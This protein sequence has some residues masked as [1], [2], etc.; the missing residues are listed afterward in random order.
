MT[1]LASDTPVRQT[2]PRLEQDAWGVVFCGG[3]SRRMGRDKAV[4]LLGGAS[5]IDRAVRALAPVTSRVILASGGTPRYPELGL[6]CVLDAEPGAG[7]L[8]GLA[9]ALSRLERAGATHA[10]VL[11]CDMPRVDARTFA[12]LLARAREE[13]ADVCLVQTEGGV[14]PLF[15]VYHVRVRRAVAAALARGERRMIAFH[16][17]AAGASRVVAV[18]EA[19]LAAGCACNLNTPDE[20]RAEGGMLA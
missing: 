16:G 12:R 10:C 11:A 15:G 6:E 17:P 4:L 9:A 5:L 14:E 3:A 1:T 20:F 19:E 13:D 7:P 2:S 18:P 8:G